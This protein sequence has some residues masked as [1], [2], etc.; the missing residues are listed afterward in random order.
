MIV[1]SSGKDGEGT[2]VVPYVT[3]EATAGHWAKR[4][5]ALIRVSATTFATYRPSREYPTKP[6][7]APSHWAWIA[8]SD[9]MNDT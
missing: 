4:G 8:G 1:T 3:N 7:G 6:G 2:L 5:H 9:R